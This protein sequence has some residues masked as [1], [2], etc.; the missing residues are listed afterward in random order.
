MICRLLPNNYHLTFSRSEEKENQI[1]AKKVLALGGSVAYVFSP[2]RSERL[3]VKYMGHKVYDGD[4]HD[5]RFLQKRGI[6]GLRAKGQ[7]RKD[8]S[9]FVIGL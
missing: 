7:A 5:L 2:S 1:Q 6:I 3:P 9:G 4:E 8:N